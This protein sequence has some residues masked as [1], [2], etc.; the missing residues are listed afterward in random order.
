[1]AP[2]FVWE[3]DIQNLGYRVDPARLGKGWDQP[4]KFFARLLY[5]TVPYLAALATT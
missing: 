1:M 5:V 4:L 2:G 3:W